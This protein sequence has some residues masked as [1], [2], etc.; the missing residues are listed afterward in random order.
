MRQWN[1]YHSNRLQKVNGNATTKATGLT[2]SGIQAAGRM[3]SIG[4]QK[5]AEHACRNMLCLIVTVLMACYATTAWADT[6]SIPFFKNY[7]TADY[8]AH[9]RNYDIACDD[10]GTV[11]V[12]NFEGL[13]YF[14]GAQ[15]RKIHTPRISRVTRLAKGK[16]GR[17]WFGGYNVFGYLVPDNMGR[18]KMKTLISDASKGGIGEVDIIKV[19]K[20]AIYVHTISGN[21]YRVGK[22]EKMAPIPATMHK[23]FFTQAQD[24]ISNLVMPNGITVINGVSTGLTFT[25]IGSRWGMYGWAPLSEKEGLTNNTINFITFNGDH[26]VW[27]ATDKGVFCVEAMSPYR[28]IN[29]QMGLKGEVN[30]INNIKGTLTIGTSSGLYRIN[31]NGIKRVEEIDLGCWQFA[32]K[33][34]DAVYAA[35]SV[36][37]FIVTKETVKRISDGNALSVCYDSNTGKCY[38]GEVDGIYL[39]ADNGGRKRISQLEK[40][41]RIEIEG[42]DIK[43][44]TIYGELWQ[45]STTTGSEKCLRQK[46][47]V[48][49]PK[50]KMNDS[51]GTTWQTDNNGR[52]LTIT[53]KNPYSLKLKPWIT[54]FMNLTLNT[55]YVTT[56]GVVWVGGDFGAIRLDGKQLQ[57]VDKGQGPA[58]YIREVTIMGDSVIWGGYDAH[59]KPKTIVKDLHMP[60]EYRQIKISFSTKNMSL[61]QPTLYRHR[62]DGG[63]WSAWSEDTHVEFNN[64]IFGHTT[65]EIQA[66]DIFGRISATSRVEWDLD[67]PLYLRWWALLLYLIIIIYGITAF[68]RWRTNRLKHEKEKL[69]G[70]VQERT[71]ELRTA[72]DEQQKISGQLQQAYDEQQKISAELSTTLDDLKRTQDNLV[73][74][75]RTATA[76][77]LTQGLI[78]RILNPINYINNFSKLTSG[79]AKDLREDIED[80]KDN[81]SEDN[82]DDC[83]DILNMMTQNLSKIEEH[84]VNTTRTLRAMEAMLNNHVGTLV[85]QD[86]IPICQQA[87]NVTKEHFKA[88]IQKCG[89][90]LSCNVPDT[91]V[92]VKMDAEAMHN[93]LISLLTN[94]IYAVVK[95]YS[96]RPYDKPE[97][98]ISVNTDDNN[99]HI[100]IRDNGIGIENTIQQK[101]FDPFF[102]TKPTGEA[103]GVGLY[104]VRETINDHH[105]TIAL[106][107]EQGIFCQFTIE[108]P[109]TD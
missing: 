39:N 44:T 42:N 56:H 104:L 97:V 6:Y 38:T 36:G 16:D 33:T 15:W 101:V 18:L 80:E 88:D 12:A 24:S 31:D 22:D 43:A 47:D 91:H 48:N 51:F 26:S 54:P 30:C 87:V 8:N 66:K 75:E 95:K 17:I 109:E 49:E 77:K 93:V 40:A 82:Y 3:A 79:L 10:Y 64:P 63:R 58:P 20:D 1:T 41:T 103:A 46:A 107:S 27:G 59:M 99:A 72:Y 60:A 76:G 29:E 57:A 25:S 55:I 14:D 21:S 35:T 96:Q 5:D 84:G 100:I 62:T 78:D 7:T 28:M 11:F 70:I 94:S 81:I 68:F 34:E 52:N 53:S 37:L 92:M 85:E 98:S 13:L 65:L 45:I 50:L 86:V 105:G 90:T 89:I 106:S 108:L 67:A 69:E 61:V 2:V 71:S 19:E 4:R 32:Q 83:D 9:N 74:M 73:R 23:E 102:T